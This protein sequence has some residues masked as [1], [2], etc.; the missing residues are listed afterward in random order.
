MDR[1]SIRIAKGASL[2]RDDLE[3]LVQ[4]GVRLGQKPARSRQA[5]ESGRKSTEEYEIAN[6]LLAL[7]L[8]LVMLVFDLRC[9]LV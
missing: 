8:G 3:Y 9:K 5:V 1:P 6:L 4:L 7:I 2:L